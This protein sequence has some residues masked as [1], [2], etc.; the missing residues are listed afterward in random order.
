MKGDAKWAEKGI[1]QIAIIFDF[2]KK[3]KTK[4]RRHE[5]KVRMAKEII[6][7]LVQGQ[8]RGRGGDECK[9]LKRAAGNQ[10]GMKVESLRGSC[11]GIPPRGEKSGRSQKKRLGRTVGFEPIKK[12]KFYFLLDN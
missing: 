10:S 2:A 4:K 9:N 7:G 3:E 6:R 5:V 11:F 1:L 8:G 12:N